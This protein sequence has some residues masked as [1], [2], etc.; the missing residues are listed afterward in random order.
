VGTVMWALLGCKEPEPEPL[1]S[2]AEYDLEVLRLRGQVRSDG[3]VVQ[4]VVT[5]VAG[6]TWL[7][8]GGH[9]ELA[10]VLSDGEQTFTE[11]GYHELVAKLPSVEPE[12]A[13]VLS[14]EDE[15]LVVPFSLP[16][17]FELTLEEPQSY[18]TPHRVSW[19]ASS[20]GLVSVTVEG[21]CLEIPLQRTLSFDQGWYEVQPAD[22]PLAE[23]PCELWVTVLREEL[24]E[25]LVLKQIRTISFVMGPV[26]GSVP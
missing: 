19:E 26:A 25:D 14:R 22:L 23:E 15:Q 18:G 1:P 12:G 5:L 20:G 17:P 8:L 11:F 13:M 2:S 7:Q 3:A 6:D 9:D 24:A 16:P 10:L 21:L 4:A